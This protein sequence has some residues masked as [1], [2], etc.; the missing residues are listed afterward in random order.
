[1]TTAVNCIEAGIL[2]G[3]Y[4]RAVL[5][6]MSEVTAEEESEVVSML[7]VEVLGAACGS[8][9]RPFCIRVSRRL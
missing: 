4:C 6:G 2:G 1:M 3:S 8:I 9:A 7:A 5:A